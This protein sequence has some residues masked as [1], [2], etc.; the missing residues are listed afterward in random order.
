MYLIFA[1]FVLGIFIFTATAHANG[2]YVTRDVKGEGG[3]TTYKPDKCYNGYTLFCRNRG[4]HFY[5]IDME[6]NV[7][8]TWK[9]VSSIHFAEL[10]PNGHLFYSTAD[11]A[12]TDVP[13]TK[14]K[15]GT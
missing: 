4:D 2:P 7:L 9:P 10:L 8:H 12:D 3:V 15:S 6:G 5:L 13:E 11:R 14:G 1:L